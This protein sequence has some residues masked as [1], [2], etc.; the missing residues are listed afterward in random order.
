[1]HNAGLEH[2]YVP[3]IRCNIHDSW[4]KVLAVFRE[5][6]VKRAGFI[7]PFCKILCKA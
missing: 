7:Q 1:L 6:A 4:L 2:F 3:I 5:L